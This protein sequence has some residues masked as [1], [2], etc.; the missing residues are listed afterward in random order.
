MTMCSNDMEAEDL[1][2]ILGAKRTDSLSELKRKYQNLALLYHPDKQNRNVGGRWEDKQKFIEI[3]R[4]WKILG[5]E[6]TKRK[7]DQELREAE[8]IRTWPVDAHID[9]ED[10]TYEVDEDTYY[11]KCRCGGRYSVAEKDLVKETLVSCD[12]CSLIIQILRR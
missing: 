12:F 8:L 7:Y 2:E 1:Y 10:M 3:S 4:A 5:N 11:Y 6:E 9:L